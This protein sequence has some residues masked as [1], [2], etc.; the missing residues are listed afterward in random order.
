MADPTAS[1]KRPTSTAKRTST[2]LPKPSSL[3]IDPSAIIAQHAVITGTQPITIGPHAVL[4]PHGKITSGTA[5]VVV[6]EGCIVFEKAVVGV[7]WLQDGFTARGESRADG[8][9][10][11]RNV[12]VET[13]AVVEAA[14]V[15]EGTVVEAG[16]RLGAGV[17]VGKVCICVRSIFVLAHAWW[18]C[19]VNCIF[20][21]SRVMGFCHVGGGGGFWGGSAF[22]CI[23]LGAYTCL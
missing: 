17:V 4:H 18:R 22:M 13:G 9:V 12:V 16:A 11:G 1:A 21:L 2:A 8:V 10:L 19:D 15:G 23:W 6:G 3:V 20:F 14:E 7:G 5:P